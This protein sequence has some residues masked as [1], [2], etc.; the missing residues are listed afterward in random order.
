[1]L[2]A[3]K[4]L[5]ECMAF[6]GGSAGSPQWSG[7]RENPTIFR[8]PLHAEYVT[9]FSGRTDD[10]D[11]RCDLTDRHTDRMTTVTLLRMRT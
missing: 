4:W 1:M 7:F 10:Q 2:S 9:V 8:P 11:V 3:G 5:T 6:N